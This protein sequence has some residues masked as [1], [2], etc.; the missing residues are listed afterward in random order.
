M[1]AEILD[2]FV[3]EANE[4]FDNIHSILLR[5][6]EM[7]QL[8]TAELDA[9]FRDFHTLKGGGGS[10][11]FES[12]SRYAH[13]LENFL[14]MLKSRHSPP[15]NEMIEFLIE[16]TGRL[17]E[18]MNEE[19][20]HTTTPE[21]SEQETASLQK[22]IEE[23]STHSPQKSDEK[24]PTFQ[25]SAGEITDLFETLFGLLN[26]SPTSAKI[27]S[28]RLLELFRNVHTLKGA[29]EFLEVD[30]FPIYLHEIETLLDKVRL[31]EIDYS[32]EIRIFLIDSLK[33]AQH[34][35]D[36]ELSQSLDIVSFQKQSELLH[37]EI[38]R[39]HRQTEPDLDILDKKGDPA[40][41]PSDENATLPPFQLF[42]ET[43]STP[44]RSTA[45]ISSTPESSPTQELSKQ[46][47]E[48]SIPQKDRS[49]SLK[50]VA[51]S[52]SIRVNLDKIDH[53]M[54]RVGDLVITKS[55]L[56]E[57]A[58]S[59]RSE[60]SLFKNLS[61]KLSTLDRDIRELQEAVMGVRMI[62]MNTIYAR[63]PKMVRDL[64][65][66]LD[67]QVR[68]EH[69]GESVEI[70][71]MMV[72]GLMDPLTH[73]IRNSLDH[74]IEPPQIRIQKGKDPKGLLSI[75][76]SQES[77]NIIISI[78]DDGAGINIEKVSQKALECGAVT[79]EE[80]SRMDEEQKRMLIFHP[81]LTTVQSVSTVSGRGVGMDVVMN[82]IHALGGEIKVYSQADIGT[83]FQ[84]ILPLTLA[85]LDG[86]NVQIGER[87]MILPLGN[88][89]ES[90]QPLPQMIKHVGESDKELLMLRSEFI[91]IIR[92][93]RFFNIPAHYE[94]LHEGMLIIVKTSHTKVALFV[95]DFLNQE[96]IVV[97][98]LEKNYKKVDGIGAATI[99]GDGSIGLILD[100]MSIV[101]MYRKGETD[102]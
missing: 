36:E 41:D 29:S 83:E 60:D 18:I 91:P 15:T 79:S 51:S 96:Q 42:E 6:E 90:L 38:A 65:K 77:G 43:T 33:R 100:V 34:I 81:G 62:P 47:E 82:N 98:S 84:L 52:T 61:E 40:A 72:E 13:I 25:D 45:D 87:Q 76:A 46:T 49:L 27:S 14:E 73:I 31:K 102:R 19:Y 67:K 9:L 63:L 66:R 7:G 37:K 21:K 12:F 5:S 1:T 35:L 32:E 99:R 75:T 101:E 53:L 59:L 11:G 74:G 10:V 69:T 80:L 71:K 78:R 44:E 23:F 17:Q 28:H 70:D 58:Q 55:M 85:I 3:E 26:S 95:D 16:S 92:L 86:L 8:D 64:A 48:E 89:V 97:K 4:L 68:F 93:H 39:F 50:K 57:F 30:F 24:P 2:F 94:N 54:N 20:H 56:F 22:K 88:I